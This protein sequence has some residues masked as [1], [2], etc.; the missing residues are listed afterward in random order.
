M[1][2]R[3][4]GFNMIDGVVDNNSLGQSTFPDWSQGNARE[5][6]SAEFPRTLRGSTFS[7]RCYALPD[8]V[9]GRG[10]AAEEFCPISDSIL[11]HGPGL[12]ESAFQAEGFG[13]VRAAPL[14]P[15]H[16]RGSLM[17]EAAYFGAS[18]PCPRR[19][20]CR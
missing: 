3:I 18:E 17:G 8:T 13:P 14:A 20:S 6:R 2:A 9:L 11:G 5:S 16:A 12:I 15:G 4:T 1:I 7:R 10:K 19:N